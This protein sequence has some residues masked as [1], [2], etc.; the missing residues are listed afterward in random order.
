MD[1]VLSQAQAVSTNL[2]DQR[3]LFENIGDKMVT[4]GSKFP[5]VNGLL[6]AIRRK[7]NKVRIEL[8]QGSST[9]QI[10]SPLFCVMPGTHLA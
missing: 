10:C 1:D 3:R 4:I 2:V 7:K 5:A 9:V 8:S 6:N